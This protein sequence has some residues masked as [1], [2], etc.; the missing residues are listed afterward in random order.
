MATVRGTL[1]Q[2]APSANVLTTMYT[3]P[4]LKSTVCRVIATETGGV[5]ATFRIAVAVSGAGDSIEQYIAYNR[6]IAANDTGSTI[7]FILNAGDVVR[8]FSSTND[9]SFTLTGIERDN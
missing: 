2:V 6:P 5:V 8:V 7:A 4:S 9:V 3:V 1:G